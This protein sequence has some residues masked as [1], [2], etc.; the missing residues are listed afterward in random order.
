MRAIVLCAGEGR[1]MWPLTLEIPKPLL[2]VANR[3]LL[4]YTLR[5][6]RA[7]GAREILANVFHLADVIMSWGGRGGAW[8]LDI[9]WL[10]E[11][12]LTGPCGPLRQ[13]LEWCDPDEAVIVTSSDS[14]NDFDLVD[15]R[16]AHVRSGAVLTIIGKQV[17]DV[18][19]FGKLNVEQNGLI[20][21]F[22]EKPAAMRATAG[23]ASCGTYCVSPRI[24]QWIPDRDPVDFGDLVRSLLSEH[25][26]VHCYLSDRYWRDVGTFESFWRANLDLASRVLVGAG[27]RGDTTELAGVH[28]EGSVL[29]SRDSEVGRG[30][31]IV[32][33][34]V[35]GADVSLGAGCRLE[36]VVLLPG[37][38]LGARQTVRD[39]MLYVH[40]GKQCIVRFE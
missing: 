23:V 17:E 6:M 12:Q 28:I 35:I 26:P 2:P 9:R 38:S 8:G 40:D 7:A 27:E 39:A 18:R 37:V 3:P 16:R 21:G 25:L 14:V 19:R 34:A 32:G 33:P 4:D 36:R 29:I 31:T 15:M 5:Q 30:V 1:R 22:V 13:F 11:S 24:I 10:R 20:N